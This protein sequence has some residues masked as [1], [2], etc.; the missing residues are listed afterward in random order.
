MVKLKPNELSAG[1]PKT[2]LSV[3]NKVLKILIHSKCPNQLK[4][5]P[6]VIDTIHKTTDIIFVRVT[7]NIGFQANNTAIHIIANQF[8]I[9]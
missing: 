9:Y 5:V 2:K 3:L 6:N 7:M 1:D 8:T 4:L